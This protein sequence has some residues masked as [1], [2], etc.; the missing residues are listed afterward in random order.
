MHEFDE[1]SIKLGC[2]QPDSYYFV[3][4][5][6]NPPCNINIDLMHN[7]ITAGYFVQYALS[8]GAKQRFEGS[9]FDPLSFALGYGSHMVAD[10]VGFHSTG[11]YLGSTVP[12]YITEFPF[13]SAIDA[14]AIYMTGDRLLTEYPWTS[15]VAAEFVQSASQY[16]N[17][18][19]NGTYPVLNLTEI[20]NCILPWNDTAFTLSA[21][22]TLQVTTGYFKEA[23]IFF[24][25]FGA[26]TYE[27][28]ALHWGLANN[29]AVL[30][31][32][33][34][35]ENI[36]VGGLTPQNA[37]QQTFNFVDQLFENG[38]CSVSV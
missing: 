18:V 2:D 20:E 31:I 33:T 25:M 27:E 38:K 21:M 14:Q 26:T 7:V 36:V 32:Q 12:S 35:A 22:S 19:S 11:A 10:Y 30:A 9:S 6:E 13:M 16:Y 5:S 37:A 28:A 8:I 23:L 29:C 4:F 1:A 15:D 17:G 24:D 3:N 34:W